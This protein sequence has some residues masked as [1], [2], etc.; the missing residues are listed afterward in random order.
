[1]IWVEHDIRMV[2]ELADNVA[3]L[4]YGKLV[5]TGTASEA[6]RDPTVQRIFVGPA[7]SAEIQPAI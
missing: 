6:L 2:S 5:R 1:M 7:K 4:D 3:V